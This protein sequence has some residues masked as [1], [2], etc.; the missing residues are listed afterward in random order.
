ME[1]QVNM[2]D[3]KLTPSKSGSVQVGESYSQSQEKNNQANNQ[4][5][6]TAAFSIDKH[7]NSFPV[8]P[9]A[10]SMGCKWRTGS[11]RNRLMFQVSE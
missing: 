6:G 7:N 4:R 3:Q 9:L 2:V 8:E 5:P 10:L 11:G 1:E